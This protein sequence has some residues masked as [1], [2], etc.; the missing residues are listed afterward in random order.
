MFQPRGCVRR[1][2]DDQL[3]KYN[4]NF[5]GGSVLLAYEKIKVRSNAL[6]LHLV[7]IHF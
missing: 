3:L 6:R 5:F 2:L 7:L 1:M 4:R